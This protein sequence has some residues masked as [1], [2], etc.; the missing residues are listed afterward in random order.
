MHVYVQA[1]IWVHIKARTRPPVTKVAARMWLLRTNL[2][3]PSKLHAI[4]ASEPSPFTL[5]DT[6]ICLL[7]T[8]LYFD[9]Y[10]ENFYCFRFGSNQK[11]LEE[12]DKCV[13]PLAHVESPGLVPG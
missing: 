13:V 7:K 4:L 12:K 9:D 6:S 5:N 2:L 8:K 3:S 11:K 1:C 10:R